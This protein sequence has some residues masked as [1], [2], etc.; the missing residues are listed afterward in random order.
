[1]KISIVVVKYK[2]IFFFQ[3]MTAVGLAV[4]SAEMAVLYRGQTD[5]GSNTFTT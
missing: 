1:M 4:V 5:F 2:L 3:L